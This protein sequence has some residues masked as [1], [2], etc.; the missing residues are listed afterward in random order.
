MLSL[1]L[2]STAIWQIASHAAAASPFVSRSTLAANAHTSGFGNAPSETPSHTIKRK[3]EASHSKWPISGL[4]VTGR[5]SCAG[6]PVF[7]YSASPNPRDTARSPFTRCTP[8]PASSTV[9][10]HRY[11]RS[12]SPGASGLWSLV[13][14]S[15]VPPPSTI[16][17]SA[18]LSSTRLSPALITCSLYLPL[19]TVGGRTMHIAAVEPL[20]CWVSRNSASTANT[21]FLAAASST[22]Q[23]SA[24]SLSW[25]RWAHHAEHT[26]P[27]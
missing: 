17:P 16:V 13:S 20:G 10:P 7:L 12:R 23:P 22:G 15:S 24:S 5:S 4:H 3:S 2:V 27:P 1:L 6:P 19:F 8:P 25:R 21:I 18:R 14:P 9:P 11:M 26:S